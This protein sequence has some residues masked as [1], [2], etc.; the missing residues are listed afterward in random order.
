MAGRVVDPEELARPIREALRDQLRRARAKAPRIRAIQ[1]SRRRSARTFI[2]RTRGACLD[3]G[4]HFEVLEVAPERALSEIEAAN[5][6]AAV[7]GVVVYY[8]VLGGSSDRLLQ[9][10][11]DPRKDVEGLSAHW[12]DALLTSRS[13]GDEPSVVPCTPAGIAYALRALAAGE[14]DGRLVTVFNRSPTVGRPLA[15]MLAR[16]GWRVLS[17]DVEGVVLFERDGLREASASRAMALAESDVVVTG[18]PSQEFAPVRAAEVR[19]GVVIVNFS[20][21]RNVD[22]DVLDR[23]AAFLPR[24]GPLTVLMLL[25]NVLRLRDGRVRVLPVAGAHAASPGGA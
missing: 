22:D 3:L 16:L 20:S 7:E 11:V 18:V 4:V 2:D 24:V 14:P 5:R 10:A 23:A 17:F 12:V 6:D 8:P 19:E 13:S 1:A 21:Y 9:N 15:S 25:R